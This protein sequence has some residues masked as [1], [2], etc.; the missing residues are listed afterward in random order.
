MIHHQLIKFY[1]AFYTSKKNSSYIKCIA[2]MMPRLETRIYKGFLLFVKKKEHMVLLKY[3]M[4]FL[5]NI[6]NKAFLRCKKY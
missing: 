6:D 1:F 2:I 5:E 3:F 4:F